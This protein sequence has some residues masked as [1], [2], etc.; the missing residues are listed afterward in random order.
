VGAGVTIAL[1]DTGVA[2]VPDLADVEHVNVTDGPDGDGLGHGTFLAGIIA[3]DGEFDGVAPGA[4]LVDVQVADEKG[5]T[6]LVTVLTGLQAVVDRGDVDVVN[7][8]LSTGS[9]MPPAFDPLSRAL[10][11]LWGMGVT[12]VAAAGNDGPEWGTVSS[13]GND[14]ILL[15]V[16]ALDEAA[17]GERENDAVA[18]FSSRGSN[19]AKGKPDLV[20]PGVSIVSTKAP[21]SIAAKAAS[22]KDALVGDHYMRGS[23][24]S[25]SAA[26]VSGAVAALLD[27]NPDLRPNGIKALLTGT[28]YRSGDLEFVDGAGAGALDLAAATAAAPSAPTD[29]RPGKAHSTDGDWGPSEADEQAWGELAEAWESGDWAG[30]QAAW[31]KLSWQ[32]QQWAARSWSMA[33]VV[34][35][36]RLPEPAFEARSW[37]ARSWSFDEWLARSWS[38]RSWSARS[39]SYEEWLARSW[40]A[41]SWSARSW[42]ARSWSAEEWLA[43]SWSARSWSDNDWAARSWSARSWSARSWSARSW[44]DFVWEARS[45]SA[46]SWSARSWSMGA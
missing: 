18:E 13:P 44:S 27:V 1:V 9:P 23:G 46:R 8:S 41:R 25:M 40:S 28:A 38:A 26:V 24:T 11:R 17:T 22:D 14:P 42:S 33:V 2:D 29:V 21:G 43:R 32:T 12:V 5:N 3:G 4:T 34:A 45:W 7:L 35:A 30:V 31:A 19:Y 36:L 16:G 20:A 6:S 37:S 39:W 15:T 10:E